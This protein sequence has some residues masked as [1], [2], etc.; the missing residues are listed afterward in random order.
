MAT[1]DRRFELHEILCTIL[2][3]RNVYYQVP[4]DFVMKYPC[5]RYDFTNM[6]SR[7][8]NNR[9]YLER[10]QYTLTLIVEDPDSDIFDKVKEDLSIMPYRFDRHYVSD[11][12]HHYVFEIYY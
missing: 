1:A 2:G 7:Y 5:I 10:K 6:N 4:A 12:L 8:A 11:N 9:N 3:S